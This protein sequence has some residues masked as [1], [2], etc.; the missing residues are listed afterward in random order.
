[1]QSA[2]DIYQYNLDHVSRA[3]KAYDLGLMLENLA[4][5]H[6]LINDEAEFVVTSTELNGKPFTAC[7]FSSAV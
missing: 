2:R 7:A 4:L 6:W 5:P 3:L 1:M